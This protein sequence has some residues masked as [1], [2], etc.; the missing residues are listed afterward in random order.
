MAS[1]MSIWNSAN[2]QLR[3][4]VAYEPGKPIEDVARELG[5]EPSQ[6]SKL[7]SNENPLGPSPKAL[8]AMHAALEKAH[9]Y[10]DGG[11]YYLREAIAEKFGVQRANVILGNGSN[12]LIEFV[13]HAFLKPGDEIVTSKHAFVMYKVAAQLFGAK[14]IEVEDPGFAHDLDAMAAAITPR[15]KAVFVANPNNPTGT[16]ASQAQIDRF[17]DRVPANVVIVFDEAYQEFLEE[18]ADTLKFVREGRPNVLVLRT[19][20]KIQGLASL[21]IGYGMGNAEIIEVLQ[22]TREPFNTSGIAQAGALAALNDE[23]HQ[24]ATRELSREGREYLERSFASAGLEYI[25]SVANFVLVKVG[26][27][28]EVFKALM[29][30][31]VII[32]DMDA[33][34]LP[35]WIRVTVGTMEENARFI[36]ELKQQLAV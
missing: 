25:P 29:C 14:T 33:Y 23:E 4:L 32:R 28:K 15:T 2:P 3:N 10:P 30:K 22:K 6:I 27:G 20:S 16:L 18:P 1:L 19:F 35:E 21:R 24:R 31:G 8:E 5:L 26:K 13:G 9:I 34:G 12:E 36:R 7:A 17:V 11:G